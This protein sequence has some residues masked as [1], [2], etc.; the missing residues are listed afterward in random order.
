VESQRQQKNFLGDNIVIARLQKAF[1]YK[2]SQV[3]PAVQEPTQKQRESNEKTT[4]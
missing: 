1:I 2:D 4:T 3:I